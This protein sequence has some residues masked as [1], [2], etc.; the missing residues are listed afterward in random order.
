M[1]ISGKFYDVLCFILRC[2]KNINFL[3]TFQKHFFF[4]FPLKIYVTGLSVLRDCILF[5]PFEVSSR[6]I[7]LLITLLF[8]C[9]ACLVFCTSTTSV[10]VTVSWFVLI[11]N[12]QSIFFCHW[13]KSFLCNCF[14]KNHEIDA[15]SKFI[16]IYFTLFDFIFKLLDF[17]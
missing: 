17:I 10:C 13:K 14:I 9:Y 12:N 4:K 7:V 3:H 1:L 6:S 2:K 8:S 5:F 11:W 16:S 15:T